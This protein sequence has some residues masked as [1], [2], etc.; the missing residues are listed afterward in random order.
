MS[1]NVKT[2]K[3]SGRPQYEV[4]VQYFCDYKEKDEVSNRVTQV[5]KS[6][7]GISEGFEGGGPASGFGG[8]TEFREAETLRQAKLFFKAVKKYAECCAIYDQAVDCDDHRHTVEI[9]ASSAWRKF[10]F[11]NE[12][13]VTRHKNENIS[14]NCRAA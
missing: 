6:V 1:K 13:G 4:M 3:T 5:A 11:V 9:Y 14:A 12:R 7:G 2:A 8:W 10:A